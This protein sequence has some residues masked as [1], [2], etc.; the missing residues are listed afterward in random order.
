MSQRSAA[1]HPSKTACLRL[2][3]GARLNAAQVLSSFQTFVETEG[4]HALPGCTVKFDTFLPVLR[5]AQSRGYVRDAEADYVVSGLQKGFTL[6]VDLDAMGRQGKRIFRNYPTAYKAHSSVSKAVLARVAQNKTLNL[7]SAKVA[8]AELSEEL[9]ALVVFPMGAVPKPNQPDSIPLDELEYRP[10]DDHTRTGLNAHTILGI[11]GHSVNTYKE[12][13]WLLKTGYF[14]SVSDVESAFLLLPLHPELWKFMFFRWCCSENGGE[15]DLF[16]HLFA[17]FGARGTPGTF[18][19]FMVRVVVQMA[20]SEMVLTLPMVIYV[21]DAGIISNDKGKGDMELVEFQD[22]SWKTCGVPWKRAKDKP[23][24]IPQY[25]IGFWWDSYT[26]TRTLDASKLARYLDVIAAAGGSPKLTLR[27]RQSLAGKVQRA[28][29]TMPPGAA[30]LLVNCY[31]GMARLSLPWHTARTSKAERDDYR[32]VH[33]ML[34]YNVGR[35]YYSYD[36]FKSGPDVPEV[37]SDASKSKMYTGGGYVDSHGNYDFFRYGTSA[38]RKPIDFLEGDVVVEVCRARGHSWKGCMI[39]FGID[40]Q[41]FQKS[42]VKGRSKA[43]RLNSLLKELFVL[44]IQYGFVLHT[45]WIASEDNFLADHLSRD[46]E[47]DFL[48]MLPSSDFLVVPLT[49]IKRHPEAGRTRLLP[50]EEDRGMAA[51]RQ[52]LSSYSS[53]TML[54]GPSRGVGVGGD[55]QL[56]SISYEFTTIYDGLP[57]ELLNLLDEVMD[58]RLAVS[59]RSKVMTG[60]SRWQS[61][62]DSKGWSPLVETGDKSRGGRMAAWVLQMKEDTDLVFASI[63]TYVWGMRTWQV[64]QHQADPCFGVMHWREFMSGIAVLTAVP[65]EP[66]KM[67]PLS[68][69]TQILQSLSPADFEDAQFGLLLNVLLFTFSRTECPCPKTWEGRDRF[70]PSRHWQ[71]SDFKLVQVAGHWVLYVRFKGIKQDKRLERPSIR[72]PHD[73][74]FDDGDSVGVGHDWVPIGDIPSDELFSI[75]FW[76]MAAVRALGRPR[77]SDEPMFLARDKSRPYTYTCL[78]ADLHARQ[79]KLSLDISNTPHCLRVLGYNLSKKANG[80]DITVAHGG[81]MSSA[82]DR[83]ERFSSAQQLSIPANMMRRSSVFAEHE[84]REISRTQA[85]R[86]SHMVPAEGDEVGSGD[87]ADDDGADAGIV[88]ARDRQLG[89]LPPGFAARE[90]VTPTGRVYETYDGPGG[91]V[92]RSRVAAWRVHAERRAAEPEVTDATETESPVR[93]PVVFS[94]PMQD[95]STPGS[96]AEGSSH[97]RRGGRLTDTLRRLRLQRDSEVEAPE[98]VTPTS[99]ALPFGASST[100]VELDDEH[101]GNPNCTRKSRNGKHDGLC[102]FPPPRPRR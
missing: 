91:V 46:R 66:R 33:D 92:V 40:N 57:P 69:L 25:Y 10:T 42:A 28:I 60:F 54:D 59:S 62:C 86:R 32:F 73:L 65:G 90:H 61:F 63:S 13:E 15:E 71:V 51:L 72:G 75:S 99:L 35:G 48:R 31:N 58:N 7:G 36:G 17:D 93:V 47:D 102:V 9:E 78:L 80:E 6:G 41:A 43:H 5:R 2:K 77:A 83:Y 45:Y 8:L 81:W 100:L 21:D 24:A 88:V 3:G 30:C 12:V 85:P 87:E 76:Y 55:S 67:F 101:C 56:L 27:D 50:A 37:L 14:M 29:L 64:L 74:P 89:L 96:S 34:T 70:D 16:V 19:L 49:E 94:S 22:W 44:Q 52:L 97:A 84:S 18:Q 4:A 53:N 79:V 1:S 39:F 38:A 23:G 11:L 95:T 98:P 68:D 82:H 26:L 20:R